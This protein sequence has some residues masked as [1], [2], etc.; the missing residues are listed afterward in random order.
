MFALVVV[1]DVL[2]LVALVA[3]VV[4]AIRRSRPVP[5][6]RGPVVRTGL[7]KTEAVRLGRRYRELGLSPT[8][9]PCLDSGV[10]T[11]RWQVE[12]GA[13]SGEILSRYVGGRR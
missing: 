5:V 10:P 6:G 4:V 11:G 12:A 2:G 3:L 13:T 7:E 9:L 1:L 8:V